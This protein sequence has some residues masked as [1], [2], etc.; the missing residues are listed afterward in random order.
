MDKTGHAATTAKRDAPAMTGS[1]TELAT[2]SAADLAPRLA[3]ICG[4][5]HVSVGSNIDPR[6]QRDWLGRADSHPAIVVRPGDTAAVAAVMALCA[7]TRTAVIPFGG[8]SGLAGGTMAAD[9]QDIVLLS[10]ERMNRIREMNVPGRVMV[11]EAGCIIE[12]LHHAAEAQGLMFP[13]VFG[14]KGTAQIGGALSTNAGGLNVVRYGNARNL[15][16]GLEVVTARGEV[17]DLLP[18]LKKN[19]TGYD[20]INLMI[21]AEGTLG[22]ITA[23]SLSLVTPPPAYATAMV[24]VRD[25]PAAL[26]LMNFTQAESGGRIEAFELFGRLHYELC[27]RHLPHITPPFAEPA[28]LAVMIEIAAGSDADA[29]VGDDGSLPVTTQLEAILGTALEAGWISDA[30]VARSASQRANMWA[31]RED[32][33]SAMV[34]HGK[35]VMNDISFQVADLPAAIADLD[36]AFAAVAPG[37]YG[38]AFGHMGDGNLHVC[39]RPYDKDPADCP[40]EAAAIKQAVR[41]VV[42]RWRG[43]ISAEHGIGTEKQADMKAMKDPAAYAMMTSIK[44]A[45]DPDNILNPGKVL[46]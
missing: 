15:C 17:M 39:A 13:L 36:A 14:A 33:L 25:V 23:A 28:D 43:S 2:P 44:A 20:L 3:A 40:A 16:L 29:T 24:K 38:T 21:G 41:D 27:I 9:G 8:N 22:I 42:T 32:V 30:V 5:S 35:W 26:E 45:L 31:M 6:Y 12:H 34:A 46:M 37:V 18:A 19:N 7:E 1:T 4:D 10:L 11:A